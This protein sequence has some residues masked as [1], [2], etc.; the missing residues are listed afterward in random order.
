MQWIFYVGG[1]VI[2]LATVAFLLWKPAQA[3]L[4]A[5]EDMYADTS[6]EGI[7]PLRDTIRQFIE[8][9]EMDRADAE[10]W[11]DLCS[12]TE[13]G[14]LCVLGKDDIQLDTQRE[15]ELAVD[16]DDAQGTA[17]AFRHA[18]A[19]RSAEQKDKA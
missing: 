13:Y 3:A 8:G 11:R 5:L 9:A 6:S 15:L 16:D 12:L 14:H 4:Q 1:A 18:I 10:R 19:A 7:D 2:S 17:K